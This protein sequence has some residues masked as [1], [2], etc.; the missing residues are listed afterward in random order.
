[1]KRLFAVLIS[2]MLL[3]PFVASAV[4]YDP[5]NVHLDGTLPIV[6][7]NTEMEPMTIIF[8]QDPLCKVEPSEMKSLKMLAEDTGVKINFVGIPKANFT[9]QVNLMLASR[10][11]RFDHSESAFIGVRS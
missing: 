8:A 4:E 1:M 6:V 3:V 5:A 10:Q 11:L 9:E 2:I 7:D